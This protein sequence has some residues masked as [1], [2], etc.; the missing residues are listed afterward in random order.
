[1]ENI[2]IQ[3]S[4]NIG[5]DQQ[6]ASI[7]ERIVATILDIAFMGAYLFLITFFF[8]V[9][10]EPRAILVFGA[11][12]LFYHLVSELAMD[13]QSWGK[14]IMKIKVVKIDGSETTPLAFFLRWVF[15][16]IDILILSG[17]VATVTIIINGKGQ[18]LGDIAA[19]TTVIRL[20]E[21]TIKETLF[22][23]LPKD[24]KVT[25]PGV[26]ALSEQDL[27]TIKEVLQHLKATNKSMKATRLADKTKMALEE[28]MNIKA[29]MRSEFF[30]F[31]LI[32]DYN[33]INS[34]K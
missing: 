24:Y 28:K 8:S 33:Y 29:G 6:V 4:Q 1:M 21:D 31:T 7:G 32:R 14:K 15:R 17:G 3:T 34:G 27:Y 30:L 25:F 23:K 13:G 11:P 16:L 26:K 2:T 19:N 5:I 9:F 20:K 18:R 12:L 10:Q 22:V